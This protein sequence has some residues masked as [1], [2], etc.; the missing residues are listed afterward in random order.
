[1]IVI[2]FLPDKRYTKPAILPQKINPI[3]HI[4]FSEAVIRVDDL[5]SERETYQN[6]SRD[7]NPIISK[8]CE[9]G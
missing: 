3:N 4:N 2:L 1:L 9:Y 5:I 6:T 7:N 8:G